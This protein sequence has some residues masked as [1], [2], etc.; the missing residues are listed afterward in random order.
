MAPSLKGSS[1]SQPKKGIR[2]A[3]TLIELL[4]V[5]AI[6]GVL[7]GLLLPA[8]NRIRASANRLACENN[9]RQIG[10]GLQAANAAQ[11]RL[12]PAF[13]TYNGKPSI[14][15]AT[16]AQA[17]QVIPYSATLFY[18]LLPHLEAPGT[19]QRFPPLFNF[20]TNAFSLAPA[21][22]FNNIT[23]A[24]FT[25]DDNAAQF[26]VP[27]YICP[28]DI[29]GDSSGVTTSSGLGNS[30]W[31]ENCYAGNYFVFGLVSSPKLP[32]SVP[33]GLS[34]T[35][36]FA[37]KPPICTSVGP[38]GNLWAAA[39]FFPTSPASNYGGTFGYDNFAAGA[40]VFRIPNTKTGFSGTFQT[41]APGASCDPRDAGSPHDS[42]INVAMGDGSAKFISN[43]ISATTWAAL[44]T[45]YPVPAINIVRPDVPG[46]DWA[47]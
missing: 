46:S 43:S 30:P 33:D 39:P 41:I 36:F 3:F 21:A 5:I 22:P 19:Y 26:K 6:I 47:Q 13:G 10:L 20:T 14:T 1:M 11:N 15:V 16:G 40:N 35:I 17:G 27:S 42:G 8:I 31:G 44:V 32:E 28:S 7:M 4:V 25:A 9:I 18:H 37:E 24:A 34:S 2:S 29:T 12:P 38:G 45:P 23:N